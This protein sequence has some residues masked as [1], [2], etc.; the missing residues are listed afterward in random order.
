MPL[1]DHADC[2][3]VAIDVQPGFVSS[4]QALQRAEWL[5]SLARALDVPVVATEEEPD[6]HGASIITPALPKPTFGAAGTP[7]ILDAIK[8]RN[9][10]VLVGF[11]T[12]VCIYQSAVGLL[13]AG[14]RV[15][16]VEDASGSPGEF[17]DRGLAR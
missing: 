8:Q 1:I 17:H 4:P 5:V 12:D 11:E 2:V 7:A 16:V 3:L 6:R 13:D 15:L 10:A 14:L 9:T